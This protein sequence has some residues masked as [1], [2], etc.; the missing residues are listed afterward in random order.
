MNEMHSTL[1]RNLPSFVNHGLFTI[2][3]DDD[4]D[5]DVCDLFD[6]NGCGGIV[7]LSDLG[8]LFSNS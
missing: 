6:G 4:V 1:T 7:T 5:V 8:L 3:G 2:G